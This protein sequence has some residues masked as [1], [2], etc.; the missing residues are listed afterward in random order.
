[1]RSHDAA[2]ARLCELVGRHTFEE[3]YGL[4]LPDRQEGEGNEYKKILTAHACKL[5]LFNWFLFKFNQK[6]KI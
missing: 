5:F 2:M 6:K 4:L 3:K 1:M